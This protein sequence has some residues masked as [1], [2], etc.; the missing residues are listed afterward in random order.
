MTETLQALSGNASPNT[1]F[2]ST[3]QSFRTTIKGDETS[4]VLSKAVQSHTR[5]DN[6]PLVAPKGGNQSEDVQLAGWANEIIQGQ[7]CRR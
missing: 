1:L 4:V 2:I 5:T 7:T 3:T 6:S